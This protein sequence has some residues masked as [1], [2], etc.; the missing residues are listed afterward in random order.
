MPTQAHSD[1]SKST[2]GRR[3]AKGNGS[4]AIKLLKADHKEVSALFEAYEKLGE[5]AQTKK[6]QIA[7]KICKALSVHAQ[8]EEEIFYPAVRAEMDE[9]ELLDEAEVEHGSIKDL[10]GEIEGGLGGEIDGKFD[11]KV[12][13]LSEWVKHHVKEEQNEMFPKVRE[14]DL[15]LKALGAQLEERKGELIG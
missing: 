14:L 6:K 11:A 2:R 5:K 3:T 4:D 9:E 15:D 10:V 13:V 1:T 12:K 7:G 8:I